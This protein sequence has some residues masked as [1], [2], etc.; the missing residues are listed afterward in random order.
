[1]VSVPGVNTSTSSS[2]G[3]DLS[4]S[5]RGFDST[6]TSTLLD[7]HPIGPIGAFGN[8]FDYQDSPFFGIRDVETVFGS[9]A[10]GVYGASTIAGA[11]NFFTINPTPQT[12]ALIEQGVG[13]NGK[14]LTGLQ[15]TGT[16]GKLGFAFSHGVEG[17]YGLFAPALITQSGLNGADIRT[18]TYANNTY[19]VDGTYVLRNDVGKLSYAF[20]PRTNFTVTG[21]SATS[22][23]SKSGNGD[24]DFV[25]SQYN[26]YNTDK[27]LAQNGGNSSVCLSNCGTLSEVD[28]TCTN[29][30][31]AALSDAAAGFSCLTPTAFSQAV[32]G[33]AGGGGGP[34]QAI[35]NQDYHA[36]LSQALGVG[37]VSVD[38]YI[39]QYGL[40]YN[41]DSADQSFHTDIYHTTGLLID[42]EIAGTLHDLAFGYNYQHQ[43]HTG[44]T[45]PFFDQNGNQFNVLAATQAFDL[46]EHNFFIRDEYSPTRQLSV[47]ANLWLNHS[48]TTGKN[49]FDPRLTFQYRPTGL[50]VLRLTA[51]HSNSEPD[52]S[53]LFAAPSYNT[54]PTNINPICGGQLNVIGGVSN[55]GLLPETASDAEFSYGRRISPL[56]TLELDLYNTTEYNALFGAT[57]PLS[58]LGQTQVPPSLIGAYLQRI[59]S[60]C[61]NSPTTA[62]LGVGTTY[63]A[64]SARY[65]GIE[66]SG[67]FGV[68]PHLNATADYDVQSSAYLNVPNS[69]LMSNFTIINGSQL[70]NVPLHKANLGFDYAMPAGL[71]VEIDGHYIG[72]NN[73]W[74]R[75]HFMFANCSV[76]ATANHISTTLGVNNVF[77]SAAQRYGYIGLGV[78][79]AENQFG[80]DQNAFDQSSEE[81]GLPALQYF[82]TMT[83][84]V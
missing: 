8:G 60:F 17:T 49:S 38:G 5:I 6:E 54:T 3:D 11:V 13:S 27:A 68:A 79:H 44:F 71:D 42:D 26:L 40:D 31:Q 58:A 19:E 80:T 36:R 35:R 52:P 63:N 18:A 1:L 47:F 45:Y 20:S 53:L 14:A 75:P 56:D 74:N 22:W 78:F 7:D 34:W 43:Q 4:V 28:G 66:I 59:A 84:K 30:Q 25:T 77:N 67:N 16:E 81:F 72:D 37:Q 65:R 48:G 76:T 29:F 61:H 12:H 73:S 2:V 21:Y 23:D 41:R 83:Y 55:P 57:L 10:T 50:D 24:N 9:G 32:A 33:P 62:D 70:N 15:T 51:G 46:D 39:D 82:F 64:A 69:I